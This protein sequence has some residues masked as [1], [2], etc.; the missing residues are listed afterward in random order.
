M[1]TSQYR[2]EFAAYSSALELVQYRHRAGL[3]SELHTE[4]IYERYGDLFTRQAITELERSLEETPRH[5]ETERAALRALTG[6]ARIGYL[7]AHA[8]KVTDE[9]ARCESQ[10]HVEWDGAEIPAHSV[11]K[12]IGNEATAS[13]RHELMAR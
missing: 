2:S 8:R 1:D 5:Q 9:R 4:P 10:A 12:R 6:A 11:P 3:E 13:R 7:E